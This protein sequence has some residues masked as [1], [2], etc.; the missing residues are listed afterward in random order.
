M[1]KIYGLAF[2]VSAFLCLVSCAKAIVE[3]EHQLEGDYVDASSSLVSEYISFRGGRRT[4]YNAGKSRIFAE[5]S[6]WNSAGTEF[7]NVK[8][9]KYCIVEGGMYV[10]GRLVGD[11]VVNGDN[12]T[13]GGER[14]SALKGFKKEFYPSIS[15]DSQKLVLSYV[16][17]SAS[18][19]VA[20][21]RSIPEGEL[22]AYSGSSWISNVS[23]SGGV[24]SFEV[25]DTGVDR[26]G[27]ITL[28]YTQA[29]DLKIT[30]R[31]A[32]ST[33][34]RPASAEGTYNYA[35]QSA[36][37]D[38]EI[39]NP[40]EGSVLNASTTA[41]WITDL[42]VEDGKVL[43]DLA[44]NSYSQNRT[45][46]IT[47]SYSGAAD[48]AYTVTQTWSATSI[49]LSP[50]SKTV[51][52][53]GGSTTVSCEVVNPREGAAVTATSTD[54][55][56]SGISVSGSV[57]SF[58]V[59]KLESK[60]ERT[61]TISVRYG[62]SGTAYA[63]KS[64]SVTQTGMPVTALSLNKTTL[65]LVAGNTETLVA[66]VTP[67]DA[68]LTWSSDHP[69][70]ASVDDAGKVTA[71]K[72]GSAII[73]VAA[74]GK[75]ASC[76]VTVTGKANSLSLSTSWTESTGLTYG[77]SGTITISNPS[78]GAL[79]ISESPNSSV[80]TASAISGNK[81]TITPIAF[82]E[83]SISVKSAAFDTFVEAVKTVT[84]KV[85]RATPT[86]SI[87]PT[88]MS[89]G[90]N[91]SGTIQITSNS[92]C[93][94]TAFSS[95][96]SA[97]TVSVSGK[98]VTVRGLSVGT[99]TITVNCPQTSKYSS[100]T[101]LTCS[102]TVQ[103]RVDL[104]ANG[105][106]NCYVVSEAGEYMFKATV[107]GNSTTSVGTPASASVLW[108]S[109][110]TSTK[111]SV[112]AIVKSVT[113]SDGYVYFE[114]PT[115]LADGN[116]VI[117]VKN[118]SGTILWSWHIWVCK[119]YDPIA[120]AQVYNNNAGTMMD[121]N[122]GAI[123]ATP[124]NV[125][126][127][128]LLYQ[129]GR[130]DPFLGSSSISSNTKAASTL[131]WPAAVSSNSS[132]G[133]INYAVQHP[134]AF[135]KYNSSNY[136]WYYTGSTSTDN[137]RWQT[138]KGVYDPCPPGWRVPDGGSSGVWAKAFGTSS[139]WTTSSNWNSTNKGMNFGSTDKK[140]GSGTIWYPAAGYLDGG[141]G[142][143]NYVGYGGRCWSCTPASYY[144][145]DLRFNYDG[146]VSTSGSSNRASGRSVRCLLDNM[147]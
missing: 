82:G 28:E 11:V 102:C 121:R 116:A 103:D 13:I 1:R 138:S 144:A 50:E 79:S 139:Y 45:A 39:E 12:L 14:Y 72:T 128:G 9:Q 31:Q 123:S 6:I 120:K 133:T 48:V 2:A 75:T 47:L 18:V 135:I 136:D 24:L 110:G 98:T 54:S 108:E 140:L 26:E 87:S 23:V 109:Y 119:D 51:D 5:N 95:N 92:D 66:T 96:T 145:Y 73:S 68:E 78:G 36:S 37:I 76:S 86:F 67:S 134:T 113:L 58:K 122:L 83:T 49:T 10:E 34:I 69:E 137:T 101:S 42:R 55:W 90:L 35:K 124:G 59:A 94:F 19:P 60:K 46:Q 4:S 65:S 99:S 146:G 57:L 81:I 20:V 91:T 22:T 63:S 21:S 62:T 41:S 32:P 7:K 74:G 84:I 131:T 52:Y 130:K 27:R 114:T 8:S 93:T 115:T 17:Q 132:N 105:T 126:A 30:V 44:E 142:S 38:V 89:L 97:A 43:F 111:P 127:L 104:S 85:N 80:A 61:G 71:V 64:L 117:A 3:P 107:K 25:S 77:T 106:A 112:G 129:W 40:V 125:G 143:L 141:D 33:F 56:I 147:E 16:S 100:A 29:E 15:V 53:N 118:S 70:I 88:T